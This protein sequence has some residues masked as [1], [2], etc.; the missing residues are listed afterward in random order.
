MPELICYCFL[1]VLCAMLL[2][3]IYIYD[4]KDLGLYEFGCWRQPLP[5]P[6]FF[7]REKE[8]MT[9][10]ASS[11]GS[12]NH[13][14]VFASHSIF[15]QH[16]CAIKILLIKYWQHVI[17]ATAFNTRYRNAQFERSKVRKYSAILFRVC[18]IIIYFNI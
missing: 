7:D 14:L 13:G 6:F 11:N 10:K 17:Y 16:A 18:P 8:L 9:Q 4:Y 5:C 12:Y 2:I 3:C 1:P 15:P